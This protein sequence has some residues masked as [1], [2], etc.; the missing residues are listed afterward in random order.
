MNFAEAFRQVKNW[1]EMNS[2]VL[3]ISKIKLMNFSRRIND[4]MY[5]VNDELLHEEQEVKFL[6]LTLD[7]GLSW[8]PHIR[9]L[10]T[11]IS[12]HVYLLPGISGL[13]ELQTSLTAYG[14]MG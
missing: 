12:R 8:E 7:N 4:I 6:G 13:T 5:H 2:L 9:C 11:R 3:I 14:D 10:G 1:L